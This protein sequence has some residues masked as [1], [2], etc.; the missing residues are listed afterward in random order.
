MADFFFIRFSSAQWHLITLIIYRYTTTNAKA[1]R[2]ALRR[3]WTI[4]ESVFISSINHRTSE[5]KNPNRSK[6]IRTIS[7]SAEELMVVSGWI[8]ADALNSLFSRLRF[9]TKFSY[10]DLKRGRRRTTSGT[11]AK[12][13][14]YKRKRHISFIKHFGDTWGLGLP[15]VQS[16]GSSSYASRQSAAPSHKYWIEMQT[17]SWPGQRNGCVGWHLVMSTVFQRDKKENNK[18]VNENQR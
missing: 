4:S 11:L 16:R 14:S 1:V 18:N 8:S 2:C 9:T 12:L 15:A 6:H 5:K 7:H 3:R 13:E 17:P 10:A